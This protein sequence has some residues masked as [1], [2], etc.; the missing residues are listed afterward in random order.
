M[1]YKLIR[2]TIAVCSLSV[3]AILGIVLWTNHYGGFAGEPR[4]TSANVPQSG[5]QSGNEGNAQ[6]GAE[7]GDPRARSEADFTL[8]GDTRAF[9]RDESFW[10]DEPEREPAAD[11][12]AVR[13][14]L[15]AT[16]VQR[17]MRLQIV[18]AD[19]ALVTGEPF[20]IEVEGVGSYKDLDRDGIVYIRD[21][22][23]GDYRVS[24][25]PI[26]GYHVSTSYMNVH[27]NDQVEYRAIADIDLL[28]V[29]EDEIDKRMEEAQ[30]RDMDAD[31]DD[32]EHVDLLTGM[33]MA[34]MG[35]DISSFNGEID[36]EKI[37]EQGI[38]FVII[39]CGYRG[40]TSGAL[41]EDACFVRNI[42]GANEAGVR[43]GVYFFTQALNE[44]EAV[45][46]ASMVVT[47]CRDYRV[48]LP[49]FID[50]ETAARGAGRADGLDIQ[51]RTLVLKAFCE[52]IE[53][54]GYRAGVY[55]SKNWFH[56]RVDDSQLTDY[57]TWLAE[58]KDAPTYERSF[59]FWQYTSRG[60]VDGVTGRVDLNLGNLSLSDLGETLRAEDSEEET[61]AEAE[62]EGEDA[63]EGEAL[64]EGEAVPEGGA[65]PGGEAL[66]EG[67]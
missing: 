19:G 5:V 33:D 51:T 40:Y 4:S 20:F 55:A 27:V 34:V 12:G 53:N 36:W 52:T 62:N 48:D 43:V 35:M 42:S 47:L 54:A 31:R 61:E 3:L 58:Y 65:V 63:P 16:S 32:T 46:E 39:R 57:L 64:P 28:I 21:L 10:D 29:S 17:D 11:S 7:D 67:A 24:V 26:E 45:E 38:G 56:E 50:T 1:D 23:A 37:K 6:Q 9:L 60:Y 13:L 25:A 59:Q 18:D 49:V 66:P 14:S 15:I 2:R 8:N 30:E 44:V 41:V 22:S